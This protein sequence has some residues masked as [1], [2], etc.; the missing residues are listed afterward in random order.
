MRPGLKRSVPLD[1]IL[2]QIKELYLFAL[3]NTNWEFLVTK[4]GSSLAG[5]SES[6]IKSCFLNAGKI[7]ENVY[8]P[9][10][11]INCSSD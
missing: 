6:E 11:Y 10:E 3:K 9:K 5:Y 4:I 8:L 7:P 1:E 2:N